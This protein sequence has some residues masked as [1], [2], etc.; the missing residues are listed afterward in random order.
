MEFK[1]ITKNVFY[2]KD[3]T[4]IGVIKINENNDVLIIDTGSDS[5]KG[6]R[7]VKKLKENG[8]T[9][10]YIINTHMHAD[11]IGGNNYIQKNCPD[12]KI[13]S[14]RSEISF[15]E[16][17]LFMPYLLYSG[18]YP[19]K[20]L[21]NKFL[22][23]EPS[24]VT[25]II[26]DEEKEINIENNNIKLIPL[27][28]HTEFHK[29]ILFDN[30]LFCGDSLISEELLEKHKI[31]VNINIRNTKKTLLK[32][33]ES[34]Y[35]YYVPSHGDL[36]EN[37]VSLAKTNLD[38]IIEIENKILDY[39]IKEHSTEE[40]ITYLLYSYGIEIKNATLYYLYNTTILAFLSYLKEENKID[41]TYNK[42]KILWKA[43]L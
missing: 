2:I 13:F 30:V 11:H 7:I 3:N 25:D 24:K 36:L 39:I 19:I 9:V 37:I 31:P 43:I 23:A 4:N 18:A 27:N 32:L 1:N 6:R 26:S 42:N 40:L 16:N 21:R 22:L 20:E 28:G 10:K 17:P 29:G 33:I 41:I 5:S 12:V 34:N 38:R 35:S 14:F 8:Y 15:I